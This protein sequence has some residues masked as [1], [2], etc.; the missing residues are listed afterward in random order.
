[1]PIRW[2]VLQSLYFIWPFKSKGFREDKS[3]KQR[4]TS[5]KE[6]YIGSSPAAAGP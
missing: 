3:F 6:P 1:M 5:G 2:K 4:S